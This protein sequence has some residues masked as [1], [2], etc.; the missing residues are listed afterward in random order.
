MDSDYILIRKRAR[1]IVD[2]SPIPDFYRD[3]AEAN[4]FSREYYSKNSVVQRLRSHVAGMM[5]D[6][7][8]HGLH[9]AEKVSLDAGALV[10]IICRTEKKTIEAMERLLLLVHSAGLL[11]DIMRKK[12]NHALESAEYASGLLVSYPFTDEEILDI[13]Q[14]IRNHEAFKTLSGDLSKNGHIVS[15]CLYDADKFRWGPDN[16]THTVWDMVTNAK[17][18]L[19]VFMSHFPRGLETVGRVRETFRSE[20]GRHYGPQFIDIGMDI[21]HKLYDVIKEEFPEAFDRTVETS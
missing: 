7:L 11:H 17:I 8:G 15:D 1:Q 2:A 13:C 3:Q 16:F 14:A 10:M 9:H 20:P 18:P 6:N 12:Q 21:G 5:D 4:R 19:K